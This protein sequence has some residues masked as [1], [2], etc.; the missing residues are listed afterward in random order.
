[1]SF[2]ARQ[3]L[4]VLRGIISL[5]AVARGNLVRRQAVA[6]LQSV[7]GIVKIQALVRGQ[8][9]RHSDIGREVHKRQSL[10][11]LVTLNDFLWIHLYHT[12]CLTEKSAVPFMHIYSI[13]LKT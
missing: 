13:Q 1:M 10:E 4:Q 5:Q 8:R 9:V 3:A 12:K 7:R 2:K 6:T 11:E